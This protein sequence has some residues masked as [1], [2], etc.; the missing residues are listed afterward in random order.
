MGK[1]H[2]TPTRAGGEATPPHSIE[3]EQAVIG[4]LMLDNA[5][6]DQVADLV[7][8][9]DFYRH[10]HRLIFGA[11]RALAEAGRPVDVVTLADA[12]E[13]AD[14]LEQAGG[15]A[16]LGLLAR[17]TP[18]AAN[19]RAYAD[20]VR[21]RSALRQIAAL[22]QA[23]AA[24]AFER[25][26]AALE[27]LEELREEADSLAER[28]AARGGRDTSLKA[29]LRAA[30][31]CIELRH[32]AGALPGLATPWPDLDDITTGLHRGEMIVLAGRPSM[33]KTALALN[34]AQHA[35]ENGARVAVISLE[36]T[37]AGLADRMIAAA[38][39]LP[40]SHIRDP[41]KLDG[42]GE[43]AWAQLTAGVA[44]LSAM[45]GELSL[46]DRPALT[47]PQI[48]ESL[49]GMRAS[50]GG[51]D[52]VV[53]DYLQLVVSEGEN[54]TQ[55]VSKISRGLKAIAKDFDVPM[56]ALSQLNRGL[57][58]RTDK[59]PT[60]GDLRES[61]QIEQD[62]DLI[63]FIYRDEVY[64][65]DSPDKGTAEIIIAKQRNGAT[66]T[67]RLAFLGETCSFKPLARDWKRPPPPMA[68]AKRGWS[69]DAP[70]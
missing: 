60:L 32:E 36:M 2:F 26:T 48:R 19:V 7:S 69:N 34:A 70:W 39:G 63:A 53:V 14:A 25:G 10:D 37:A 55:E 8:E 35:A 15:L 3:A 42:G 11:I 22:A 29:A 43:A 56:V 65:E 33:G 41:R 59:R 51:L 9:A 54:R 66:G 1:Q 24:R 68:E 46:D 38:S 27:A 18:S 28:E 57:E 61:G 67:V 4:G 5:T 50:M 12:L 47:I 58:Q 52:L 49:R 13:R 31:D 16:Y 23:S 17:D 20:I 40:L 30:L 64:N 44:R 45:E 62:A 6:W 21:E